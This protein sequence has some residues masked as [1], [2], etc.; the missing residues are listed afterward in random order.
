MSKKVA[1]ASIVAL[2]IGGAAIP[3]GIFVNDMIL[4]MVQDFMSEGFV[5]IEEEAVPMIEPMLNDMAIPTALRGI[6]DTGL[7]L[8][9]DMVKATFTAF[10][11]S[12]MVNG[13]AITDPLPISTPAA[14]YEQLFNDTSYSFIVRVDVLWIHEILINVQG[15]ANYLGE[16]LDITPESALLLLNGTHALNNSHPDYVPGLIK[17][18]DMGSCVTDFLALYDE[19]INET[20]P[21]AAELMAMYSCDWDQL[22][23]LVD[24]I[25]NYIIAVAIPAVIE[26]ADVVVI[27]IFLEIHIDIVAM[28]MPDL[29]GVTSTADIAEIYFYDQW[30]NCGLITEGMDFADLLDDVTEPLYGF[31]VGRNNPTGIS[32]E[33]AK[34]LFNEDIPNALANDDGINTWIDAKD[35]A[36]IQDELA[37]QFVLSQVQ[38]EKILYWLFEESFRDDIVPELMKLPPPDGVGMNLTAYSRVLLLEVWSNGTAVGRVLYEFGFPFPLGAETVFGFEIGWKSETVPVESSEM[39]LSSAEALW[40]Q[41]SSYSITTKEGMDKWWQAVANPDSEIADELQAANGL[42]DNTMEMLL[43]YFPRFRDEV[44]PALAKYVMGLPVDT[45]TLG[46]MIQVGGIGIGGV[47]IGLASTGFIGNRYVKVNR[48]RLELGPQRIGYPNRK[49]VLP[50]STEYKRVWNPEF[51][52]YEYK[53]K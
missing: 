6:R 10:L 34:D 22:T 27:P 13:F 39:A 45:T 16:S 23:N 9:E 40:D 35:N 38:V 15:A 46:M 50:P 7:D 37:T 11:L 32:F 26:G 29:A 52:H 42:S 14:T 4:D 20:T 36:T 3:G 47:L 41:D 17:D 43:A 21:E 1:V 51:G 19:A 2:F 5:G 24:Y 49:K 18:T 12:T 33:S 53:K 31:E 28:L 25:R 30:A 48:R 44:M 8:V